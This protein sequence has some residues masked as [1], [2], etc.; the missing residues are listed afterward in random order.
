MVRKIVELCD[1]HYAEEVEVPGKSVTFAIGAGKTHEVQLCDEHEK[2]LIQPLRDLI[3]SHGKA[4]SEARPKASRA[5]SA[6]GRKGTPPKGAR[7]QP[8]PLCDLDYAS[9]SGLIRHVSTEHGME[10]TSLSDIFGNVCP[11][12]NK[13][14]GLMGQHVK[15]THGDKALTTAMAFKVARDAGDEYGVVKARVDALSRTARKGR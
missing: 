12:C 11:L 2:E 5:T 6:D 15:R 8:C 3:K 10:G 7:N 14:S 4:T 13:A 1:L 9:D